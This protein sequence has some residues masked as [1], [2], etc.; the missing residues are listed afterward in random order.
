MTSPLHIER[1]YEQVHNAIERH[2]N[3]QAAE[4]PDKSELGRFCACAQALAIAAVISLAQERGVSTERVL[5][6]L[7][8]GY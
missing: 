3:S 4:M 2:A 5:T 6:D 1:D 7:A 8:P